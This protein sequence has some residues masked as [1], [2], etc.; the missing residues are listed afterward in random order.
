MSSAD[1]GTAISFQ[2]GAATCPAGPR[3][4]HQRAMDVQYILVS[5]AVRLAMS[6]SGKGAG[7]QGLCVPAVSSSTLT[8][9]V[10]DWEERSQKR[11]LLVDSFF[12]LLNHKFVATIHRAHML[13][14][15]QP[16]VRARRETKLL[17]PFSE[18]LIES[19]KECLPQVQCHD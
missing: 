12:P 16:A 18:W 9:S 8:G 3:V 6:L 14:P 15:R 17:W 2:R 7:C 19:L 1:N 11:R 10:D 13:S 5:T 4:F